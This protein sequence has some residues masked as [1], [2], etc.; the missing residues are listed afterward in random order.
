MLRLVTR[1]RVSQFGVG[2]ALVSTDDV[3]VNNNI[4]TFDLSHRIPENRLSRRSNFPM[5]GAVEYFYNPKDRK[6]MLLLAVPSLQSSEAVVTNKAA[7]KPNISKAVPLFYKYRLGRGIRHFHQRPDVDSDRWRL[8]VDKL[9]QLEDGTISQLTSA[10]V[11]EYQG[12]IQSISLSVLDNISITTR[13]GAPTTVVF[14][15]A[16]ITPIFI[17]KMSEH[18][19]SIFDVTIYTSERCGN[20]LTLMAN[21]P[22]Y[23]S[24]TDRMSP[25]STEILNADPVH[26]FHSASYEDTM[27]LEVF[28]AAQGSP[29]PMKQ[30]TVKFELDE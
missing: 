9:K 3:S 20:G 6:N 24:D 15:I 11:Q 28:D 22:S 4:S 27:Q 13:L 30:Y 5:V 2:I 19:G 16:R 12:Y 29:V 8:M 18:Y 26:E 21:Y 7:I 25:K 10:E 1:N 23:D 17:D 14:D